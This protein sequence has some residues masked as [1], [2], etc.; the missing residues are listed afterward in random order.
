VLKYL[1]YL[2]YLTETWR[3]AKLKYKISLLL[4][5]NNLN[6]YKCD[7]RIEVVTSDIVAAIT[8]MDSILNVDY[9]NEYAVKLNESLLRPN[10]SYLNRWYSSN[11]VSVNNDLFI[12]WLVCVQRVHK[13]YVLGMNSPLTSRARLNSTKIE[14]LINESVMIINSVL[15]HH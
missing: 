13:L 6:I 2:L 15:A 3:P 5:L 12:T 10:V 9:C 7:T 4:S 11:G 1:R 14:P 8:L